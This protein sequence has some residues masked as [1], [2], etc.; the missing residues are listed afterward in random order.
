MVTMGT[1]FLLE[2]W[3]QRSHDNDG[4]SSYEGILLQRFYGNDGNSVPIIMMGTAVLK[5]NM[6]QCSYGNYRNSVQMIMMGT[7]FP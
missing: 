7:A 6:I 5:S 2:L 4:N 3:E 1:A